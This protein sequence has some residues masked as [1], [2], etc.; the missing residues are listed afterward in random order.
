MPHYRFD[1]PKICSKCGK[2][3]HDNRDDDLCGDCNETIV[4]R[5][6]KL[7]QFPDKRV[8]ASCGIIMKCKKKELDKCINC[9]GGRTAYYRTLRHLKKN[10]ET[11][12]TDNIDKK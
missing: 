8:C 12:E 7:A 10:V 11:V 2:S 4:H 9:L 3:R 1:T 5:R 6:K